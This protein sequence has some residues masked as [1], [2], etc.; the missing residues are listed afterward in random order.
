M[1]SDLFDTPV[2][3]QSMKTL[4]TALL[5]ARKL[6]D[7]SIC[8]QCIS[9][10]CRPVTSISTMVWQLFALTFTRI[11]VKW[12]HDRCPKRDRGCLSIWSTWTFSLF[13][14][15]WQIENI[16]NLTTRLILFWISIKLLRRMSRARQWILSLLEHRIPFL[17]CRGV[18]RVQALVIFVV[19]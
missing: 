12:F 9:T 19:V 16:L 7:W 13:T 15:S 14:G 17:F 8:Y 6:L 1:F 10:S 3:V 18:F 11:R 2:H 5:F 4:K